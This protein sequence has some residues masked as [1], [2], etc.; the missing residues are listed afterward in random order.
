[1]VGLYA[2]YAAALFIL[3]FIR[4]K[5]IPAGYPKLVLVMQPA[6]LTIAIPVHLL[7]SGWLMLFPAYM[8]CLVL[9]F[10]FFQ[11]VRVRNERAQL[12]QLTELVEHF[13]CGLAISQIDRDHRLSVQYLS[14]GYCKMFEEDVSILMERS[15]GDRFFGVHPEDRG[16]VE[17]AVNLLINDLQNHEISYR[18]ITPSGTLKWIKVQTD[19]VRHPDGA[20]TCYSTYTD[21][22]EQK[23]AQQ[24]LTDIIH[25]V[26]C[27][28]CLYHWINNDL[29][30]I[31]VNNQF[32]EILGRDA[33]K[34]TDGVAS[35]NYDHIHEADRARIWEES[36][37]AFNETHELDTTYRSLNAKADEYLWIRMRGR[38]IPQPDGSQLA[39]VSYYDV[40]QEHRA[41]QMLRDNA[42]EMWAKYELERK[43]ASMAEEGLL[44]YAVF[45]LTTGETLEYS[46]RDGSTVP[47]KDRTVFTYGNMNAKL[48]I[49]D[50]E[51]E[52]F[53]A[54]NDADALMERFAQGE[55]EFR[56]DYRRLL[57][58][59]E[60]AWIRSTLHLLRDPRSG[61]ILLF[62]YWY[63][64]EEDKMLEL[65][66][67]SIAS[68]NYDY[69]AR[70][71]GGNRHYVILPKTGMTSD[72]PLTGNDA[73]A[74]SILVDAKNIVP[75]DRDMAVRNT[76]V[77]NINDN[78][79]RNGRFQF[80]FRELQPDGSIRHKKITQYYIDQQRE[81][82]AM[83]REDVT[84]L[85]CEEAE[86]NAILAGALDAA[87]QGSLAKSQF[88]SRV[89]HELRTPL[90]AII[91]FMELAKD[92]DAQQVKTYL[93]NSDAAAKQLLSII[94][95][96]LDVSS[97]E[98]G[99]LRIAHAPFDFRHLIQSI[100]DMYVAQCKQ[101]GLSFETR[102][103][104]PIS[105]W[106]LGD[107]LRVNQILLN[108][109]G[110]ALKFTNEG[111]IWLNISQRSEHNNKVFIHFEVCDT[112]CGMSEQLLSRLFKPFEQESASTAQKYGG[113]GLGLSIVSS[114]VSM[115]GGVV[116][117][118][119]V[120][121]AGSTFTVDLP[122]IRGEAE[123]VSCS[124]DGAA[125]LHV[126]AVDDL[127]SEREYVSIVLNRI[128]VR[129]TC[130]ESGEAAL[131]EL[132]RAA[133][134]GDAYNICLVDWKMPDMNGVETTRRIREKY[135]S[136][137]I[138]IVVSA[139][140]HYQADESAKAAGA[141]MFIT[142]PLF[143]SS[144]FDLFATLT[145]GRIA[146]RES[147]PT[148]R[149]FTDMHI[150]L[151][152]DNAMNRMVAEGLIKMRLGASCDCAA[153]GKIASDMF[154]SANSGYYDAILMDI[155]MPNMDGYEATRLIR[156]SSHPDAKSIPIIA[157]TANAF[158][159]DI[160]RS[161][162]CG[163]NGHITKPIEPEV[164]SST[165]ENAISGRHGV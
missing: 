44:T 4:R 5:H 70:I 91:G 83:L 160:S 153:D 54:L 158:N 138:V 103:L 88:L 56:L 131:E 13:A 39:Y 60:V 128:G 93:A 25:T 1:M 65:M 125:E 104:T 132:V 53:L 119:S 141:N 36:R 7:N 96:V 143:Q 19:V 6:I 89:S 155:Q 112:G 161:L 86:K 49:D 105:E 109:L 52:Q 164:L 106:L 134:A 50:A 22:T 140:D 148:T 163:M 136:N 71:D 149:R 47:M 120:P 73:D 154:L 11:N 59:G 27:G 144:L 61:D 114:L 62:E 137:V 121:G 63:N 81:I 35:L 9:A 33:L 15:A 87:N 16:A 21:L 29:R 3:I 77:E 55:T 165:L 117:V 84:E 28:I 51:R 85:I 156:A 82:I 42:E 45:N 37:L 64:I 142:K 43:R 122:F 8:I 127:E 78:L 94:N 90:N 34:Y 139:Y 46:Y 41:E 116:R 80:T 108:L 146:R 69:V 118:D 72:V 151:A 48:L 68:D 32:F 17:S 26:P 99:K 115:M 100:T 98:S 23:S 111:H 30:P 95:D 147:A 130:V 110:N 12:G 76:L 18:Y 135:G 145:G 79:R 150:L 157:L 74:V 40:T 124:I 107:Q 20:A 113:N 10:L 101:K 97:I 129:H 14:R 66:Y 58:C 75:D 123:I 2:L 67:R 159:E 133:D 57:P 31:I 152:E 38:M 92:A 126:L 162:S 102:L 24:Q